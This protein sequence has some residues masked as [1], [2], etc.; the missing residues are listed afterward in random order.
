M[1]LLLYGAWFVFNGRVTGELA[2]I[3][4][5]ICALVYLFAVKFLSVSPKR[6]WAAVKKLGG[7]LRYGGFMLKEI[8]KANVGVLRLILNPKEVIE[9]EIKTFTPALHTDTGRVILADSVTLTPGTITIDLKD[10]NLT[11]HCLDQS[12]AEGLENSEMEKRIAA[13]EGEA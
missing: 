8:V 1:F 10:G 7:M 3:G 4:L 9:P 11:V 2:L 5:P 13:L 12:L 6:E